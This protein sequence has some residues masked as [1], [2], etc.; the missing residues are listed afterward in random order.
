MPYDMLRRLFMEGRLK[1]CSIT[2]MHEHSANGRK[3]I[4]GR[5]ITGVKRS[6]IEYLGGE[7]GREKLTAD[8]NSITGIEF[9]CRPVFRKKKRIEK[10]YPRH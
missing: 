7:S 6:G 8:L 10:I 1:D 2:F 9:E 3:T 5:D 4:H